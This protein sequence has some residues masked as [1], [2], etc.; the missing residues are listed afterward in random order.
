MLSVEH[1][2]TSQLFQ[3]VL[4]NAPNDHVTLAW[5][6]GGLRKRSFGMIMLLL[7]LIA[8]VPG[9]SV[10][11]AL[12]LT[13]LGFQMVMARETPVLPRFIAHRSLPTHRIA[14]LVDRSVP[15]IKALEN[16]VRPR[17]HTPFMATKRFVGFVVMV[18]A[19]TLFMPIPLSNIIPGALTML[20]AFAYLEED[21]VMLCIALGTS[22]GSLAL[23]AAQ[24]WAALSGADFLL[25][26]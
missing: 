19:A 16:L 22:L 3:A 7:G 25:R 17:W 12:L 8:M 9:I 2:P 21:G 13:A 14:W 6:I 10:I 23:T 4:N 15:I 1:A 11:A 20:I 24:A 18:L 5:I 26:L